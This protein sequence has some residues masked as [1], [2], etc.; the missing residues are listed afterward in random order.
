M[1]FLECEL[2]E[3]EAFPSEEWLQV[4][5]SLR[6]RIYASS[7][8]VVPGDTFWPRAFASLAQVRLRNKTKHR[9]VLHK[10]CRA[11]TRPLC[12][13]HELTVTDIYIYI[14]AYIQTQDDSA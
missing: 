3:L 4:V 5:G 2:S 14:Y 9:S 12:K 8:H 6:M 10:C 13:C 1:S 7:R 11:H